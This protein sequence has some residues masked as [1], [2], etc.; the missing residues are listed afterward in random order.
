MR[1][2]RRPCRLQKLKFRNY[3]PNDEELA[4]SKLDKIVVEDDEITQTELLAAA[5][6]EDVEVRRGVVCGL[7]LWRAQQSHS[8][9]VGYCSN[10]DARSLHPAGSAE[11]CAQEGELGLEAGRGETLREAQPQDAARDRGADPA[12][13]ERERVVIVLVG[14]LG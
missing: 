6:E 12:T 3:Q 10:P 13:S 4:K 11:Y 14:F 8:S 5:A 2:L 7:R 1:H 9:A